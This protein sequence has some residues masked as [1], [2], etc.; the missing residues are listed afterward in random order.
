MRIDK[1]RTAQEQKIA[2]LFR[3]LGFSLK[4]DYRPQRREFDVFAVLGPLTIAVECKD[5]AEASAGKGNIAEFSEKLQGVGNLL[6]VFV[7]NRFSP[8][9]TELCE[10]LDIAYWTTSEVENTLKM[11]RAG[12]HTYKHIPIDLEV[13]NLL[14]S[15]K[16]FAS[17]WY[18]Y[19]E[20]WVVQREIGDTM[21]FEDSGLIEVSR[22]GGEF[23][24][25]KTEAGEEFFEQLHR[26]RI[27]LASD[28][29]GEWEDRCEAASIVEKACSWDNI[30]APSGLWDRMILT[31]LG[32]HRVDDF[33]LTSFGRCLRVIVGRIR[34]S[35]ES[36]LV[37]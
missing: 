9:E 29:I 10:E 5:Y 4:T 20:D 31:S 37:L 2:N 30:T 27:L 22:T 18:D 34:A 26:I 25:S 17:L 7:A 33:Q 3:L 28:D 32:I 14:S 36:E 23:S 1:T 6:G 8:A 35:C 12:Q 11:L 13:W 24:Y 16:T 19:I 15:L 21:L